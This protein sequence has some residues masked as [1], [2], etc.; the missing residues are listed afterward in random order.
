MQREP[1]ACRFKLGLWGGLAYAALDTYILRGSAPWT[2]R[3]R[4]STECACFV[5][6]SSWLTHVHARMLSVHVSTPE[7]GSAHCWRQQT[8]LTLPGV[9]CKFFLPAHWL[10]AAT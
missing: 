2:L 1:A 8:H 5:V 3:H 10:S 6:R 4:C 9:H 7:Q